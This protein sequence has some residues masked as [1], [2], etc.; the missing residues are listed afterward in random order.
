MQRWIVA[1]VIA[2]GLVFPAT[3]A[4]SEGGMLDLL[5]SGEWATPL[6]DQEMGELRGG[7]NGF[8][9][10]VYF[11]G[12][13]E[14]LGP[15]QGGIAAD[16]NGVTPVPDPIID[17]SG[18][19]ISTQIGAFQGFSGIAQIAIVPGSNNFVQNN[20]FLQINVINGTMNTLPSIQDFLFP[21]P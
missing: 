18:N 9:F 16:P 21:T 2:L 13:I 8:S 5:P 17:P 1:V 10:A 20:M 19:S 4:R 3:G 6:T 11:L 15:V 7:F 12:G 14:N